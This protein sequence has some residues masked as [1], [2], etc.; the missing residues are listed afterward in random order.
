MLA[1]NKDQVLPDMKTLDQIKIESL[2]DNR[3]RSVLLGIFA[4]IALLL[5]AIGIYGV[6]SHGV[7]QR[8]RQIG[9]RAALGATPSAI[10]KLILR[11][12]LTVVTLGLCWVSRAFS[13]SRAC[14]R[15][16]FSELE[17]AIPPR[18]QA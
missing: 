1:V 18:S 7:E 10:M 9:L 2:G 15:R 12:G 13:H 14:C 4:A 17:I 16:C 11:G 3:L 6:V 5:S 8:T